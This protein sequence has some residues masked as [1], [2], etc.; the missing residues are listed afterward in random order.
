MW[1]DI[2]AEEIKQLFQPLFESAGRPAEMAFFTRHEEG[3]LHCEVMAYF[4]SVMV[5]VARAVWA[6]LCE[7]PPHIHPH[8]F[9]QSAC[10]QD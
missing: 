9:K 6:S 3:G 10:Q 2:P 5:E 8:R 7:K 1:A 4:S